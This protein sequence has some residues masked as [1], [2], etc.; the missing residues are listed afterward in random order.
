MPCLVLCQPL[1][2]NALYRFGYFSTAL[3]RVTL[4]LA[5]LFGYYFWQ[6]ELTDATRKVFLEGWLREQIRDGN[7]Y[8]SVGKD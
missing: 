5:T 2:T 7:F 6:V 4:F 1:L 8:L 3:T